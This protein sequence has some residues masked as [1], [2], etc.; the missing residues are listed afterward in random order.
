MHKIDLSYLYN[1]YYFSKMSNPSK[2]VF[3]IGG[4]DMSEQNKWPP[5]SP[6]EKDSET[7]PTTPP[8]PTTPTT[9]TT[10]TPRQQQSQDDIWASLTMKLQNM[11]PTQLFRLIGF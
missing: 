6:Q 3:Y 1:N 7:P 2:V 9:L 4:D 10:S 11:N 5:T 8:T